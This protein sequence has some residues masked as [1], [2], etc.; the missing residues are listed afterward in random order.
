MIDEIRKVL[1]EN[2]DE[3]QSKKMSSYMKNM[4]PFAG[5]PKPELK[6]LIAPILKVTAKEPL[7]WQYVIDLW[8]EE[9]RE[10]QYVALEYLTKHHKELMPEDISRLETL[11]ISKSWWE[12][13]DT[14]DGF[15]GEVVLKDDSLKEVMV[16][17]SKSENMWLRRVSIDF[18]QRYKE[19]TDASL[20]E[21]IIVNNLNS[22][23]FFINKAIGWSLRE[24]SK[25]NPAWVK[26]F[27]DVYRTG[28]APLS[29][30]EASK[31]L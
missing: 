7:N 20:L 31:Y 26:N 8:N 22:D 24:Y 2:Y 25:T 14:I 21:K 28:L 30:K 13:V 10:A 9:A 1:K 23:E 12:T 17:W 29:V 11:I 5:I 15:V 6:K 4:F 16:K 3:V 19:K 27:L 18:Q